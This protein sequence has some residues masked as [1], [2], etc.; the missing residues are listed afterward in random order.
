MN[1]SPKWVRL[2]VVEVVMRAACWLLVGAVGLGSA[3]LVQADEAEGLTL[4]RLQGRVTLEMGVEAN[5]AALP[6]STGSL[7]GASVLGDYY[8]SRTSTREGEASGF[9]ATS[10]VFLGTRLGMWGG[11]AQAALSNN[12]ISVERHSFSLLAP[13]QVTD[14]TSLE[15]AAAPY[16]G[17]GYTVGSLKSGWGFSADLGMLALNPGNAV[18]LGRAFSGGPSL[19]EVLR[20]ARLS[21]LL[22]VGV[23]YQF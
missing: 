19:D 3:P 22:Q 1:R 4:P 18:R 11:H 15:S 20:D 10:G 5:A 17:L 13:P 14:G 6:G 8:F 23:S 21:P 7:G 12:L 16:L 2:V 9:R